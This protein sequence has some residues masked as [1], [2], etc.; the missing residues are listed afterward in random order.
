MRILQV[1]NRYLERGGEEMSVERISNVLSSRHQVF[2]CYFD[3]AMWAAEKSLGNALTQVAQIFHNPDSIARFRRHVAAARPDLLLFHNIFPVGSAGVLREALKMDI[4]VFQLVHNFR[5]FSVNGYLWAGDH[6][7]P[8]GLKKNF[9]PEVLAGSW[10]GSRVKT[11]V[12]AAVLY[13]MHASGLFKRVDGW[14]AISRFMRD[15]FVQAGLDPAKVHVL[16]HSWDPR[17]ELP[18]ESMGEGPPTLVFLGRLTEAKG[19]VTLLEAWRLAADR[20]P[21]ARLCIGGLG[22]MEEFV[23]REAAALPRCDYLGFV[24]GR[25]K[26]ELLARCTA[27]VVPSVWWEA[28]G[29]VAYEAYDFGKPVLAADGGGLAETVVPDQ[30]G[31]LHRPGDAGQLAEQMVEVL[32]NPA[33][34]SRRGAEGR[35]WL[36]ENT[37]REDWLDEFERIAGEAVRECRVISDQ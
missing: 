18:D 30:T 10:Q 27:M 34:A 13:S 7:L 22:P 19:V 32:T 1:F 21:D 23:R 6:L 28:L 9:L 12:Y 33:E 35:R 17:P 4:P 11:A 29:L 24:G 36:L 31:W 14:L 5:P 37:R 16:K 2:H 15:T 3:S 25:D 8:Q 20:V 26:D